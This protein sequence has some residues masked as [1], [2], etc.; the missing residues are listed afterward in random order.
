MYEVMNAQVQIRADLCVPTKLYHKTSIH[1]SNAS[2]NA[3]AKNPNNRVL[4]VWAHGLDSGMENEENEQ[5]WNFWDEFVNNKCDDM[6]KDVVIARYMARGHGEASPASSPSQCTWNQLG[7]D[8][9]DFLLCDYISQNT[10]PVG[11]II[12]GGS[13][14]GAASTLY[15]AVE[16][17]T[18]PK[19]STEANK[20][21][22]IMLVIPPTCYETRQA[23]S[24][25]ILQ[26]AK[27][28]YNP[29]AERLARSLF[30]GHNPVRGHHN[31]RSDSY[32]NVMTG[33]SLS[34]FPPKDL[35]SNSLR[36]VP[37][38]VL[39]WD[40]NDSTH[41]ISTAH[42]LL[43]ILPHAEVHVAASLQ[44]LKTWPNVMKSFIFKNQVSSL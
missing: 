30:E 9:V 12:I 11:S 23:K 35:I 27:G 29:S 17:K 15:A 10:D 14:M 5:L 43:S 1:N 7:K 41:P 21:T 13:S 3:N 31:I 18:N 20:L 16:L 19:L 34:N 39:A 44:N 6:K 33:A 22:G 2:N 25:R 8:L 28:C 36:N 40:C 37:V 32:E 4:T 26:A 38:L 42:V 24:E